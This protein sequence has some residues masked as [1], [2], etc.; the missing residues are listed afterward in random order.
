MYIILLYIIILFMYIMS[1][2][3]RPHVQ[4]GSYPNLLQSRYWLVFGWIYSEVEGLNLGKDPSNFQYLLL[5]MHNGSPEIHGY[6]L[7]PPN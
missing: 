7:F 4:N 6:Q 3:V 5:Y 2:Q 1:N